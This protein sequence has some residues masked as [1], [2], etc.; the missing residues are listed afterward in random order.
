[1]I[2]IGLSDMEDP[3][4]APTRLDV[5]DG[6]ATYI[7]ER[8]WTDAEERYLNADWYFTSSLTLARIEIPS[9]NPH[10]PAKIITQDPR[11]GELVIFGPK[12]YIQSRN[13]EEMS[14][15]EDQAWHQWR[16]E[17]ILG[18]TPK[19]AVRDTIRPEQKK[20]REPSR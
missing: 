15:S 8:D 14:P 1:M 13:P 11:S 6:L 5:F 9:K 18:L 10:I 20:N 2:Q 7:S 3:K 17:H 19:T 16:M 12:E 4:K